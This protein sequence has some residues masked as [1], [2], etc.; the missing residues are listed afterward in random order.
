MTEFDLFKGFGEIDDEVLREHILQKQKM[1]QV[2]QRK[3]EKRRRIMKYT[4]I[5]AAAAAAVLALLA[6]TGTF[7]R[8]EKVPMETL[9]SVEQ[10]RQEEDSG[11][12]KSE[13]SD[14]E[15]RLWTAQQGWPK[16]SESQCVLLAEDGNLDI[17]EGD[18]SLIRHFN[19]A[20]A[21]IP[22]YYLEDRNE[23]IWWDEDYGEGTGY[24]ENVLSQQ[25]NLVGAV[26][27]EK[28][29]PLPVVFSD[30]PPRQTGSYRIEGECGMYSIAENRW[31]F[32]PEEHYHLHILSRSLWTDTEMF[33][34][35]GSLMKMDGTVVDTSG[36]QRR[37]DDQ[38]QD[39]DTR[40]IYSRHPNV[41]EGNG[42]VYDL[43]GNL[44][45]ST[46]ERG[47]SWEFR[48]YLDDGI[49]V[50][51]PN[52]ENT[53]SKITVI[54]DY[55]GNVKYS[56]QSGLIYSG[57]AGDF[58]NWQDA[59]GGSLITD[60]NLQ[61]VLTD[62]DFLARNPD[63][64]IAPI[65][66]ENPDYASDATVFGPAS[67]KV[68]VAGY[69]EQS[70]R[71]R[72]LIQGLADGRRY[73]FYAICDSDF[74]LIRTEPVEKV[75]EDA[76]F[77]LAKPVEISEKS[78][79]EATDENI[80][81]PAGSLA[82][83][84]DRLFYI[85]EGKVFRQILA[86]HGRSSSMTISPQV[87]GGLAVD[88]DALYFTFNSDGVISLERCWYKQGGNAS[89]F[90]VPQ[91]SA[92]AISLHMADSNNL[93]YSVKEDTWTTWFEDI[94][95]GVAFELMD[96]FSSF[97]GAV[98]AAQGYY[99]V[100]LGTPQDGATPLMIVHA[101]GMTTREIF[102]A[103]VTGEC[104]LVGDCL[105][106]RAASVSDTSG[107]PD[108]PAK[109]DS[110]SLPESSSMEDDPEGAEPFVLRC[111]SF[112]DET[113]SLMYT[114]NDAGLQLTQS[115]LLIKTADSQTSSDDTVS[116]SGAR[117]EVEICRAASPEDTPV[118]VPAADAYYRIDNAYYL[119][120]DGIL[121]KLDFD[122]QK[123]IEAAR[124]DDDNTG[125]ITLADY[126]FDS[127]TR[128]LYY[129]VDTDGEIREANLPE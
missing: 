118:V 17:R 105:Y 56:E 85:K 44:L 18:G 54:Y 78:Q 39:G 1:Q 21:I 96:D 61:A 11:D 14:T 40:I 86:Q 8:D 122:T 111:F 117:P 7:N 128:T 24:W 88:D 93:V 89:P 112:A 77:Y 35:G 26:V 101:A 55:A 114:S 73:E 81:R 127:G 84:D 13:V 94:T 48:D 59:N 74:G 37:K 3:T 69:D 125:K 31:V 72:L 102:T 47:S 20:W 10:S 38:Y 116:A 42:K 119:L 52:P 49:V 32:E 30:Q 95:Q 71:F 33:I 62:S 129:R 43:E 70:A 91:A 126:V 66:Q 16:I 22:A 23:L 107:Q 15:G 65:L 68:R 97:V 83:A 9:E 100:L 6:V 12:N 87:T 57:H 5:T 45:G 2:R 25:G 53:Q 76:L 60:K 120:T 108:T 36:Q 98:K 123:T 4:G 41:V 113:D 58:L 50:T 29:E 80:I 106:Y 124:L 90:I 64:D 67:M 34:S 27:W 19:N 63:F 82:L 110:A 121:T 109:S 99:L 51:Q 46:P 104:A 75:S 115:G 92:K 79:P 103:D 28:D